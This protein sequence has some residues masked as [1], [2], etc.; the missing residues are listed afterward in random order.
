MLIVPKTMIYFVKEHWEWL[1]GFLISFIG[2]LI[3]WKAY[4]YS[5]QANKDTNELIKIA[6]HEAINTNNKEQIRDKLLET[7]VSEWRLKGQAKDFLLNEF[8]R[9]QSKGWTK[10]EFEEIYEQASIKKKGRKP[11]QPLFKRGL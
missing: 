2:A 7:A 8:N 11:K 10:E 3:S 9:L 1:T 6:L 4:R 5:M